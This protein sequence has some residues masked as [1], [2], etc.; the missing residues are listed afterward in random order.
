[1]NEFVEQFLIEARELVQQSTD[2]LLALEADP[3][4]RERLDSAFRAFHTLKGGAGIVEFGAMVSAMHAAEDLL[5]EV[6]GGVIDV[7]AALIGECLSC[8]DLV[9]RWLDEIQRGG[10]LP[11]DAG[12]AADA[13]VARLRRVR[14]SAPEVTAPPAARQDDWLG[15]LTASNAGAFQAALTAIRFAPDADSFLKG[16]D[17]LARMAGLPGLLA[18]RLAPAAAWPALAELDPFE[19]RLVLTALSGETAERIGTWAAQADGDIEVRSLRPSAGADAAALTAPARA[20]IEAQI[21]LLGEGGGDDGFVGRVASA[22]RV[23]VNVVRREGQPA[24]AEAVERSLAASLAARDAAPLA[25]ALQGLLDGKAAGG[26]AS[27]AHEEAAPL[28]EA[29]DAAVRVLRVDVE[30]ID[31]LVK[32]AGELTVAKNAL[33]HAA[34]LADR[35]ADPKALAVMLKN[36]HAVFERL[37]LQL[38]R[39]VLSLRVLPVRQ[40][41]QRFPRL[42][43]EMAAGLGKPAALALH[44][45][46]VEADKAIVEALFEPLLH[47]LRNAVDHGVE[48]AEARAAAGKPATALIH[49]RAERRGEHVIIEVEDDGRGV[50]V[51][52]VRQI[53]AARGMAMPEALAAMSDA[54]IVD[55]IFAPG[56]STAAGVTPLSGRGVGMDAVR[57]AVAQL[58]GRAQIESRAGVGATVR[59]TLPF[60]VVM[61]RVMTVEAG[62]QAFGIPLDALVETL[63]APRE[64]IVPLGAG[65]A[66]VLRERT[67]PLIDLAAS[68]GTATET[69]TGEAANLVVAEVGGHW[70]ALEVDRVGER[71]DVMLKPMEGLLAGM[72]GVAG[73]TL[74]GDGRVLIV[75][76]LEELVG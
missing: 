69:A 21:L 68:L 20:L 73:T 37:A 28:R 52:R 34:A 24:Q 71:M 45:E 6:R 30:R 19:C 14:Q 48:S 27:A 12:Q 55:L 61:S 33:A 57:T 43:R 18:L 4:D 13:V 65:S 47:V 26:V 1:M 59:L 53:A 41:F 62:G 70:V 11:P 74:L 66:F 9:V 44:G 15:E 58:G 72:P 63:R 5:A 42:V 56:F 7:T 54:E 2:D 32:L 40:V 46:D 75:L 64:H 38:Q 67:V 50:D 16:D 51:A 23:A 17:P 25:A 39:A 31:A 35:D 29:R 36:Q 22:G 76:D 8:I 60:T 3:A 10:E 49:L